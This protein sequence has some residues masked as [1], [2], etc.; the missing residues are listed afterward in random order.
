MRDLLLVMFLFVAAGF[1]LKRPYLGVA[2]WVWIALTAPA[3]WAFGFSQTFRLNLTIVLITAVS[4]LLAPGERRGT[5]FCGLSFL[6]LLFGF[7]T[8]LSTATNLSTVPGWVW[9][10]WAQFA[11]VLL[12]FFFIT[13][14]LRSY[15]HI[16]TF[17]WAIVLAISSYAAMEAVK[18]ILSGGGHRITGRAGIIADRNDLAVAINMCIPLVIYLIGTTRHKLLRLG[19]CGLVFLN[20]VSI[21]GTYS[22]GGFIGL[23]ILA[24]AFWL[25]SR[26]KLIL[27]LIA[28]ALI[29]VA[30]KY[31]P[32]DWKERQQTVA[33][34]SQDD[35][36]FIGRLWAWKVSTLIAL[37]HPLTGGGFGAVTEPGLW[38]YYAPF[39]P[40]FGPIET[41]PVPP[42]LKPKAAHNVYF[43]VLGDHGVAG[44]A[45][46]LG[47]LLLTFW[48]NMRNTAAAKKAGADW[49]VK[50]CN[51]VTLA[52]VGYGITGANVS[53]AY[54][55]LIYAIV[56]V[57]A[58]VRINRET[59]LT[60]DTDPVASRSIAPG[61]RAV[62][63]GASPAPLR[64]VRPS[65]VLERR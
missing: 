23:A 48:T 21:V 39:T 62:V 2:A 64:P 17:I 6:V 1:A 49:C 42:T 18:F 45:I 12:L 19:L 13:W 27:A 63:P 44:L 43:Q 41:P 15:I 60:R 57:V 3:E 26:H 51:A 20:V 54:F 32:E 34:A 52:L 25:K 24:A 9:S 7:W 5:A 4:F 46:F 65:I 58:V 50:L 10:Y 36:S 53:L 29:P 22:R 28:A 31:A 30:F 55:D 33:T 40:T 37:D 38:S 47:I 8:L 35:S 59:L 56:G 61:T 14:V 16:H 11:K